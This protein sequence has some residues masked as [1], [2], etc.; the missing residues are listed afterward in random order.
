MQL[1]TK[2]NNQ[3]N[4]DQIN[5]KVYLKNPS[6]HIPTGSPFKNKTV[7]NKGL[8]KTSKAQAL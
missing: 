6:S 5:R 2:Q 1:N 7:S 8:L 3:E 4:F